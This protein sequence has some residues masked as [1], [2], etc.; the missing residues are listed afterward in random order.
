MVIPVRSPTPTS[1][2]K[3]F[4]ALSLSISPKERP[5]TRIVNDCVPALPPIPVTMDMMDARETTFAIVPENLSTT[6]AAITAVARL[7][8]SQG[9][10]EI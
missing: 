2:K 7:T 8:I 4:K 9:T 5:R 10:R 6:A 1:L 3:I